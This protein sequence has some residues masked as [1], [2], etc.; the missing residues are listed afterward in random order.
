MLWSEKTP[1]ESFELPTEEPND[2]GRDQLCCSHTTESLLSEAQFFTT[3]YNPAG[4]RKVK[5]GVIYCSHIG[6]TKWDAV[7]IYV[8]NPSALQSEDGEKSMVDIP[9]VRKVTPL[10]I[11]GRSHRRRLSRANY[12]TSPPKSHSYYPR[13]L[14]FLH[15]DIQSTGQ[16]SHRVNTRPGP[17]NR[18]IIVRYIDFMLLNCI[19]CNL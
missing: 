1:D 18:F 11:Y 2:R 17:K 14:E 15:V 13:L 19:V 10:D 3:R 7:N 12:F 8:I 4:C 9:K 5:S 16:K 6:F